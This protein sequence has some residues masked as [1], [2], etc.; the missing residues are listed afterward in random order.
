MS[1]FRDKNHWSNGVMCERL[2]V[3]ECCEEVSGVG[4]QGK[5]PLE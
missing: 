3:V 4:F 2:G 5:E 1:G